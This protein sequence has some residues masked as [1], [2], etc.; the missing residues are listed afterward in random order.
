EKTYRARLDRPVDAPGE[1]GIPRSRLYR[2]P[3]VL[4]GPFD[5]N[6]PRYMR[7]EVAGPSE[8]ESVPGVGARAAAAIKGVA[9]PVDEY[10]PEVDLVPARTLRRLRH[11]RCGGKERCEQGQSCS[12]H[13]LS[14]DA[15]VST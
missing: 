12:D 15:L 9:L 11:R 2:S 10:R 14:P 3:V 1:V 8:G 5:F 7:A 13:G 6:A 4:L